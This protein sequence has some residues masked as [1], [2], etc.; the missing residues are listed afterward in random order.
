MERYDNPES[1]VSDQGAPWVFL[2]KSLKADRDKAL[3]LKLLR[4]NRLPP[5]LFKW[6]RNHWFQVGAA[7]ARECLAARAG[8][9]IDSH[10]APGIVLKR[11]R[12]VPAPTVTAPLKPHKP[13]PHRNPT[14]CTSSL[15]V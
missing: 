5:D 4:G 8:A 3:G 1:A 14:P 2:S 6:S 15:A 9:L 12:R 10:K 13:D 11:P 7:P